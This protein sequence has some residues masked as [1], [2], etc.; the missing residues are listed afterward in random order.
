MLRFYLPSCCALVHKTTI[1]RVSASMNTCEL[2][3]I[4]LTL[5]PLPPQPNEQCVPSTAIKCVCWFD[6]L[7]SLKPRTNSISLSTFSC[8][9]SNFEEKQALQCSVIHIFMPTNQVN[10]YCVLNQVSE[11]ALDLKLISLHRYSPTPLTLLLP[12]YASGLKRKTLQFFSQSLSIHRSALEAILAKFIPIYIFTCFLLS[13]PF[14]FVRSPAVPS[15]AL[16]D[17]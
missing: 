7:L 15:S 17:W 1:N 4:H 8:F 11:A 5:L 14:P 12:V 6:L 3:L 13:S 9:E 2:S 10:L 16:R